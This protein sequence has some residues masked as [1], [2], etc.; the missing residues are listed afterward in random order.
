MQGDNSDINNTQYNLSVPVR[1][2]L[3]IEKYYI[4]M[5]ANSVKWTFNAI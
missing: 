2:L 5:Q 4:F 3:F 1:A